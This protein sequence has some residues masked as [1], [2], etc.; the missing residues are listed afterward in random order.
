MNKQINKF[1]WLGFLSVSIKVKVGRANT[2]HL[3]AGAAGKN[4]LFNFS[5]CEKEAS[6]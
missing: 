3:P 1:A 5:S 2:L 6:Q 4:F